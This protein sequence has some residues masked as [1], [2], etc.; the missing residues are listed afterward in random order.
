VTRGASGRGADA[1]RF[2]RASAGRPPGDIDG[3]QQPSRRRAGRPRSA[4]FGRPPFPVI[5]IE[6]A[7]IRNRDGRTRHAWLATV[8]RD[9]TV[10]R[11]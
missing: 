11:P 9:G 10:S 7:C 5:A 2:G 1:G 3:P 4:A 8:E 6:A